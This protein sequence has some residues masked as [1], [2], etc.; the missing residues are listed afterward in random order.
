MIK[1]FLPKTSVFFVKL[2]I[3]QAVFLFPG[4]G[5]GGGRKGTYNNVRKYKTLGILIKKK[6]KKKFGNQCNPV[7]PMYQ[8]HQRE[9]CDFAFQDLHTSI[10]LKEDNYLAPISLSLW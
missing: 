5:P 1:P 3:K 8:I 7:K 4:S 9:N 6:T 2:L 10:F